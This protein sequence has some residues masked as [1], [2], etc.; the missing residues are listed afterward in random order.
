MVAQLSSDAE[1]SICQLKDEIKHNVEATTVH[2]Q[3]VGNSSQQDRMRLHQ[4]HTKTLKEI[5]ASHKDDFKK[6]LRIN[7]ETAEA[8]R[9][10]ISRTRASEFAT[11]S[12][13]LAKSIQSIG[14]DVAE[15]TT[16]LTKKI[17]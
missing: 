16:K 1:A 7:N 6:L 15:L 5:S 9:K 2:I 4:L 14:T 8:T 10:E 17:K 3:E 11:M 13:S 12:Q